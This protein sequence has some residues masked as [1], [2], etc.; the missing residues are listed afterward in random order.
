MLCLP[1]VAI[2]EMIS[3]R[4][5]IVHV[6]LFS[7]R[8]KKR[9]AWSGFK[10][11]FCLIS[12]VCPKGL[13]STSK[14][15]FSVSLKAHSSFRERTTMSL[16]KFKARSL[17]AILS[18]SL[19]LDFSFRGCFSHTASCEKD[20]GQFYRPHQVRV[21]HSANLLTSGEHF[22]YSRYPWD[23][24]KYHGTFCQKKQI[25]SSESQIFQGTH[26]NIFL[27]HSCRFCFT[28]SKS[29]SLLSSGTYIHLTG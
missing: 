10:V 26:I 17:T 1:I 12:F 19:L 9:V 5:L 8:R 28:S 18:G 24:L 4:C 2:W 6:F 11:W 27:M 22:Y 23:I 25:K 15:S 20:V 13:N 21:I 14:E 29:H 7:W 16:V 3:Q